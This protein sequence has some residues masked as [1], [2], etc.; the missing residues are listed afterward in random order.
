M[1]FYGH[2]PHSPITEPL[3]STIVEEFNSAFETYCIQ[4]VKV[5]V[6]PQKRDFQFFEEYV[7]KVIASGGALRE[8][9]R[10]IILF[11]QTIFL[12]DII[13]EKIMCP[14]TFLFKSWNWSKI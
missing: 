9:Q 7:G 11:F 10:K 14:T 5:W 3:P 6:R 1:K 13:V 4:D 8:I 2:P 12:E